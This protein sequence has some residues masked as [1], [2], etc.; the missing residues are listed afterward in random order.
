MVYATDL[1]AMLLTGKR[2]TEIELAFIP[3]KTPEFK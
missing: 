2:V 3:M 1:L